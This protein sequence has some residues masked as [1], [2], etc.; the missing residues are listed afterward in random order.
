M[1]ESS[2]QR[3]ADSLFARA[4]RL[5][6]ELARRIRTLDE[7]SLNRLADAALR[8]GVDV[9]LLEQV[10]ESAFRRDLNDI[11]EDFARDTSETHQLPL[12]IT[13]V[14]EEAQIA[15]GSLI[16]GLAQDAIEVVGRA[17]DQ[18]IR[19]GWSVPRL[20]GEIREV[21]GLTTQQNLW[22]D[23]YTRRLRTDPASGLRNELRDRRFDPLLRRGAKLDESQISR[24]T[25]RYRERWV[26]HRSL[27]ISRVE[28][29]RAS[30]AANYA[31]WLNAEE[32]GY[33]PYGARKFWHHSHDSH[34]RHSHIEIPLINPD[35]V[36]LRESFVT[37]LGKLRYPLDPLGSPDDVIGCRCVMTVQ[38]RNPVGVR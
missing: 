20:A 18:A 9:G 19:G 35:G 3:Q 34:V 8:G 2:R 22:I 12:A 1:P 14:A 31:S 25:T 29:L 16:R 24:M 32:L 28:L 15:V 36:P 26:R 13:A 33:L 23:N 21:I 37:P 6:E 5:E 11:Y 38:T 7:D 17:V 27:L 10:F 4:A 30:N